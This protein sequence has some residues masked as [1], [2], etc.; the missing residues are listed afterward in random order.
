VTVDSETG[1]T[2]GLRPRALIV[3]LY[4]AYA[5]EI[6]GWISIADLIALMAG[7]G[8]DE[9]AVRSAISRLKRRDVL[10]AERRGGVAGYTLSASAQEILRDGDR[11]IFRRGPSRLADGWLLAIFS[12]PEA[13]RH[14]R[15][16]LRSR[17]TWLG[18][19]NA[20]PGVWIAP[21]AIEEEVRHTLQR[22]DLMPYVEMFRSD[23]L[24]F[25][26]L[27]DAVASWWD[28]DGLRAMYAEFIEEY[29]PLRARSLAGVDP[30]LA[31][32]QAFAD[33]VRA[34]TA[35]RRLPFLDPGLPL[36]VLPQPWEGTR[37][38]DLFFAL[39]DRLAAPAARHVQAV[40]TRLIRAE[41]AAR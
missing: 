20:A 29:E 40:T 19:G 39:H 22:L 7:L 18:F 11:R 12:V 8:V 41:A 33:H 34:L 30:G 24:G 32:A 26:D 2:S 16:A 28:L 1:E 31:D 9:P 25:A 13:E 10:V 35:W 3:T 4:G 37:A 36:E 14:K 6:G 5:R 27:S 21:A 38:S 17:L 15:H 23:Y